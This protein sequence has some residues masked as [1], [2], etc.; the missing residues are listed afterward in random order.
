M[1][2][3]T[4]IPEL[5]STRDLRTQDEVVR[6]VEQATG[7]RINQATVS[8][9]LNALGA[10]K[11]DGVYRLPPP[12]ELGAPVHAF[13]ATANGCLAVVKTDAALAAKL[14][15]AIDTADLAGVLGTIAGEDTVFV[16]VDGPE[17]LPALERLL[18]VSRA[19]RAA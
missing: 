8:R 11:V 19:R 14:A 5:L 12:P 2:W 16:A 18:G 9:E 3:R 1:N 13:V 7:R 6:A 4:A 15:I 17:A 10:R